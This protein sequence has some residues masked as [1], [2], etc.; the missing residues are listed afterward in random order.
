MYVNFDVFRIRIY[1]VNILELIHKLEYFHIPC[2]DLFLSL[3]KY[4]CNLFHNNIENHIKS[5][6]GIRAV[7]SCKPKISFILLFFYAFF[8]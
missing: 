3:Y 6:Y 5:L 7:K 2:I 4:P 8:Y 1:S